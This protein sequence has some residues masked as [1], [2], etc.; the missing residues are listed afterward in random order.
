MAIC[1]GREE[2]AGLLLTPVNPAAAPAARCCPGAVFASLTEVALM[3]QREKL[4][5]VGEGAPLS[6][7]SPDPTSSLVH[8]TL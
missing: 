6:P 1:W 4:R 8:V 2:A 3:L 5:G 7:P